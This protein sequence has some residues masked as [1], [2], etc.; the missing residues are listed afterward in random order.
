M[1]IMDRVLSNPRI[2][3]VANSE[4]TYN[5]LIE[6]GIQSNIIHNSISEDLVLSELPYINN[7]NS[8]I[9]IAGSIDDNRKNIKSL[10]EAFEIINNKYPNIKLILV[11]D[12]H[13]DKG[14][15]N[16]VREKHLLKSVI[17]T[18]RLDRNDLI[19]YID[20][21]FCMIHPAIEE[22]FGNIL[23]EA[24]A[25]GVFC[26]GGISSGAVPFVLGN[27]KYGIT[28]DILSPDEIVIAFESLMNN[29]NNFEVMRCNALFNIKES[30]LNNVIARKH[31]S[32]YN[33]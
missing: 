24:M 17:F 9:S 8:I 5:L 6:Y 7:R 32:L 31:I 22:T 1:N 27:G 23:I 15:Y 3:F 19:K 14:I 18:G 21:S 12:F 28:C 16:I 26:I 20:S 30:Y 29:P 33:Q 11:G 25:R 4:Y 13:Q 10:I 2:S